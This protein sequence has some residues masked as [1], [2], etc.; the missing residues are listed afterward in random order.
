LPR[1]LGDNPL[2]KERKT[3]RASAH[4]APLGAPEAATGVSASVSAPESVHVA[5]SSS[6]SYNDVFFQRRPENSGAAA[7]GISEEVHSADPASIAAVEPAP[8]SILPE[9]AAS[10][11]LD[12]APAE[13]MATPDPAPLTHTE[14]V[15]EGT[16]APVPPVL[17]QAENAVHPE[18]SADNVSAQEVKS[19]FFGRIL[20]RFRK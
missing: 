2:K 3:K 20:G 18:N 16:P 4:A 11:V 12:E 15:A 13:V 19:G 14:T 9:V 1:G 7:N 10:A 17:F 5:S 8:I 6:R